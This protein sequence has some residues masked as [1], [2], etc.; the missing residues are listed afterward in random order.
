MSVR[1]R[2]QYEANAL[3]QNDAPTPIVTSSPACTIICPYLAGLPLT[4]LRGGVAVAMTGVRFM[5]QV[6][7]SLR[8]HSNLRSLQSHWR[9]KYSRC[10]CN[11]T[12]VYVSAMAAQYARARTSAGNSE[13]S[14]G[15]PTFLNPASKEPSRDGQRN[16]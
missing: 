15:V 8:R 7:Q 12:A 4:W 6:S 9:F 10:I 2:K 1:C 11:V 16:R 5:N 13:E 3:D 14:N